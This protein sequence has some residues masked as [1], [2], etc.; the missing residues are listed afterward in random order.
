MFLFANHSLV[1]RN[2]NSYCTRVYVNAALVLVDP[3]VSI[4]S[5]E[6]V[7]SVPGYQTAE[8]DIRHVQ[9][10]TCLN[11]LLP[12]KQDITAKLRNTRLFENTK[13]N[14]KRFLILKKIFCVTLKVF[15]RPI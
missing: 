4:T 12:P 11:Y 13:A 8:S 1:I 10:K 6:V 15:S 9:N 2:P 3:R 5:D 7:E 14:A